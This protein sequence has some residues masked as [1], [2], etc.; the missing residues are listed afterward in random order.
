[1]KNNQP[2]VQELKDLYEAATEF[3][4]TGCWNWM[5]D[6]DIFGVQNPV[7]GEIGYC[8]IM[9]RG[10]QHYGLAVYLGTGGLNGYLNIQSGKI[11][12]SSPD[13]LHI[14]NCL[15]ASFEDKGFL[16]EED[17]QVIKG[18]GLKF[19]GKNAYPQFRNYEPGYYPW[20]LNGEEAKYLTVVLKQV[21]DVALRFKTN[22]KMLTS[23]DKNQYLV[24]TPVEGENGLMW[25]DKWLEP[26]PEEKTEIGAEPVDTKRLEK[27]KKKMPER[28][29]IWEMDFFYSPQP[30]KEEKD[31]KPYFP[32]MVL[33]VEHYSGAVLNFNL[34][35][36][37]EFAHEIREQFLKF[38]ESAESLP[39]K[40]MVK[41]EEA[42]KLLEPITSGLG[43]HL[44]KVGIMAALE[45]AQI[46]LYEY[47]N[48]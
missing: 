5:W 40:I 1:M 24:R 16:S 8:C 44:K 31:D 32:F 29:G 9:G 38:A 21:I 34:I 47:F 25:E 15:M 42:V 35:K 26:A 36:P 46:H 48:K 17:L 4:K 39:Q 18:L 12:M 14:Q 13:A 3:Y 23:P 27:I 43:I 19:K 45:K 20:Y 6:T 33:W 22:P 30:I 2:S 37:A 28:Q 7:T 10:G 11:N 41:K